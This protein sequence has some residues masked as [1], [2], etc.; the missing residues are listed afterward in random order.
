VEDLPGAQLRDLTEL[1]KRRNRSRTSLIREAVA[2]F[3]AARKHRDAAFGLWGA[4]GADGVAYA[5]MLR[6]EWE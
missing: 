5:R 1:G 2:V 6:A 4:K 3:L